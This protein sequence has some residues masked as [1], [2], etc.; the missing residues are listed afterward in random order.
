MKSMEGYA[1]SAPDGVIGHVEDFYFD[2]A[3]WVVRYLVVETGDWLQHRKV[4]VSPISIGEPAWSENTFPASISLAQLKAS[5]DID[6]G[7][8]VSRWHEEGYLRYF[9]YPYYWGGASLWGG[10]LDARA[11]TFLNPTYGPAANNAEASAPTHL[12]ANPS[13]RSG[14]SVLHYKI[15][16]MDGEIGHVKGLLVDEETWAIRYLIVSTSK[17][18]SG[19]DVLIAPE[20]IDDINWSESNFVIDLSRQAIRDAPAYESDRPLTRELEAGTWQH[21]GREGYW[22]REATYAVS[23]PS[24]QNSL[25]HS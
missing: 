24:A 9:G 6:T 23:Y 8:P 7:K 21:Y 4:L 5:P 13:L 12:H 14:N 22:R 1:I 15:H 18:W 19:H 2:D 16:A 10:G 25:Q 17:W 3:T 11:L 20:W